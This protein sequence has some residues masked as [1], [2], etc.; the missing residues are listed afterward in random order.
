M[1]AETQLQRAAGFEGEVTGV[2]LS[3]IIQLNVA[4][5]FSGC[6]DVEHGDLRGLIFLKD[7][8]IVH[9]EQG[10]ITGEAAFYEILSWPGGQFSRTANLATTRCTIRRSC[11]FLILE[12]HRLMDEARDGRRGLPR[13]PPPPVPD[14][15]PPA[16]GVGLLQALR[17][18]PGVIYAVV[19]GRDGG[20][21]GDDSYEAE[22]LAGQ[23]LYLAM[24]SRQLGD[25]LRAGE[26][27]AAVVH[28]TARQLL[29]LAARD[30]LIALLVEAGAQVG[31]VE[32]VV[33]RT[34]T[35][36]R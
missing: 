2:G 3:D 27:H 25:R 13:R 18:I 23:A 8:E 26:V 17:S 10:A 31:A 14:G 7:G 33:R 32:T 12:A 20:R 29:L 1:A 35:Q 4:N 19:Q 34:L 9:A 21:F 36:G 22:V 11:Q 30:H 24:V 16:P 5:R 15:R 6:I 28:G